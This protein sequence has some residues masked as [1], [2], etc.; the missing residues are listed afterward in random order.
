VY[1][2]F[3]EAV[4]RKELEN[5]ITG[6]PEG[7]PYMALYFSLGKSVQ[8]GVFNLKYESH[9]Q[10]LAET[11]PSSL[12]VLALGNPL[13][14]VLAECM[15]SLTK[16]Q[17]A[18]VINQVKKIISI[19]NDE[20]DKKFQNVEMCLKKAVGEVTIDNLKRLEIQVK[21]RVKN[22]LEK[23]NEF[24]PLLMVVGVFR[25]SSFKCVSAETLE[26]LEKLITTEIDPWIGNDDNRSFVENTMSLV[27]NAKR[28]PEGGVE[29]EEESETC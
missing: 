15:S 29:N 2:R 6:F 10:A 22:E 21:E 28:A 20:I 12:R 26:F 13:E 3:S 23:D 27:Y 5:I 9:R 24:D 16:K 4:T 8:R 25:L 14:K 19:R 18:T 17:K 11:I 1:S 7:I